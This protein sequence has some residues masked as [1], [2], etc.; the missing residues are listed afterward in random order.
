VTQIQGVAASMR[1]A[2]CPKLDDFEAIRKLINSVNAAA[3]G[4]PLARRGGEWPR[5]GMRA[6]EGPSREPGPEGHKQLPSHDLV[7]SSSCSVDR[8]V[9][10]SP[11]KHAAPFTKESLRSVAQHE[12]ST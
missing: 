2:L 5:L 1:S 3:G 8:E 6:E 11:C 10:E 7:T 4:P 9:T 12:P